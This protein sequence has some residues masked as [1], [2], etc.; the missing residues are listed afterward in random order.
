MK[1]KRKWPKRRSEREPE[2]EGKRREDIEIG[3]SGEKKIER[4]RE[5]PARRATGWRTG[6]DGR[7]PKHPHPVAHPP[8]KK[9][10]ILIRFF[11]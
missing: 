5:K 2:R 4:E 6:C 7:L 8:L 9:E 11:I 3:A 10:L 1:K